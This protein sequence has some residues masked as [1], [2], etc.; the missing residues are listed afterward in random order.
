MTRLVGAWADMPVGC[1]HSIYWLF[2]FIVSLVCSAAT[3]L[4]NLHAPLVQA[5]AWAT[6]LPALR[7]AVAYSLDSLLAVST[8]RP[9]TLCAVAAAVAAC[10]EVLGAL[11]LKA[12]RTYLMD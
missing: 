8:Q 9:E 7:S 5:N 2:I 10:A 1:V 3:T 12:V 4:L 6:S 11:A